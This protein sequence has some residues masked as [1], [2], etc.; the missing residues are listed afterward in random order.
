MFGKIVSL[1][2]VMNSE[3]RIVFGFPPRPS[4]SEPRPKIIPE[5]RAPPASRHARVSLL[6]RPAATRSGTVTTSTRFG[7]LPTPIRA[8]VVRVATSI[9]ATVLPTRSLM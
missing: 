9:T 7:T 8:T 3:T 4:L 5:G 1:K 2:H 6:L